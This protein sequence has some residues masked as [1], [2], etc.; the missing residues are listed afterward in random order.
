MH[1][2]RHSFFFILFLYFNAGLPP[3]SNAR[4]IK[5]GIAIS[6]PALGTL[7]KETEEKTIDLILDTLQLFEKKIYDLASY[8]IEIKFKQL[9][10]TPLNWNTVA[11]C[12]AQEE[13]VPHN[14]AQYSKALFLKK[15]V[16]TLDIAFL[17]LMSKRQKNLHFHCQHKSLIKTFQA[18]IIHELAHVVD[19]KNN[20]S[21]DP[22]FQSHF[23]RT[24]Q[25]E[26]SVSLRSPDYYE[27][28]NIKE[29]FAVNLEYYVL[30][31]SYA[32]RR[33]SLNWKID[34]LLHN[35]LKNYRH[36]A[37]APT[38][39][40]F[41]SQ[42][43]KLLRLKPSRLRDIDFILSERNA[44]KEKDNGHAA[45]RLIFCDQDI[46]DLECRKNMQEQIVFS[47]VANTDEDGK[48]GHSKLKGLTGKY[49][50]TYQIHTF[51]S[52][53]SNRVF[54]HKRMFSLPLKLTKT[55]K[56][57]LFFRMS[58]VHWSPE[59]NYKFLTNNCAHLALRLLASILPDYSRLLS[60]SIVSP[61]NLFDFTLNTNR[62][63]IF[64][65]R[66]NFT[67]DRLYQFSKY[68]L[69]IE[70]SRNFLST[71]N[72]FTQLLLKSFQKRSFEDAFEKL[73][74]ES[75]SP[76]RL[77]FIRNLVESNN[78]STKT[79]VALNSLEL[80]IFGTIYKK[81]LEKDK[82]RFSNEEYLDLF[83]KNLQLSS[84]IKLNFSGKSGYGLPQRT[85]YSQ[86]RN[87]ALGK[88]QEVHSNNTKM[89]TILHESRN[90]IDIEKHLLI[91]KEL[92]EA[93]FEL[94]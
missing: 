14:L 23:S 69:I 9:N 11:S 74:F 29:A 37:Q 67:E 35:H 80:H 32:Q 48:P 28:K 6:L 91:L 77:Q 52:Y 1:Q 51:Q 73:V 31:S 3:S 25:R 18:S 15:H 36:Q 75:D 34:S 7:G 85:D 43:L 17:D 86:T 13:A 84:Q 65:D 4:E 38:E 10:K 90:E 33:P 64:L 30:D 55:E 87:L 57:F 8:S 22:L 93:F 40:E 70:R 66:K 54:D 24:K 92:N 61:R 68:P 62:A 72:G 79:I 2:L 46:S 5:K 39:V 88:I 89:N 20:Y 78:L 60:A 56:D 49:S 42:E 59:T 94:F 83:T 53:L 27:F 50:V 58:E 76:Q 19:R 41:L 63:K 16:I 21:S 44:G 82:K 26:K 45:F 12:E 71:Q 47:P 81:K